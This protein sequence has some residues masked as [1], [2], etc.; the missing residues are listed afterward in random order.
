MGFVHQPVGYRELH[1]HLARQRQ[2]A[3]PPVPIVALVLDALHE[4]Q[5]IRVCLK[6]GVTRAFRGGAPIC[7]WVAI[8]PG[9][10]SVRL[11][12]QIG[13]YD[14]WITSIAAGQEHPIVDPALL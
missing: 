13:A 3:A 1:R 6:H 9:G 10:S 7:L 4:D 5:P 12:V 2:I 8:T 14:R 11:V